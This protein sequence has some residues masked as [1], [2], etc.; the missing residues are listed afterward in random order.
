MKALSVTGR[1]LASPPPADW[2]EQLTQLLGAKPRRIGNWAELGL[3]GAMLCLAD[4]GEKT[5][6]LD[7]TLMLTSRRGTYAATGAALAQMGDGLPMPLTFLQTQPSQLL[8]LLSAQMDWMGHACFLATAQPQDLLRL[9]NAQMGQDG[10]LLGC[11]DEMD[12]GSS[13]WLR[14][15]PDAPEK[16]D[17]SAS[18][19]AWMP[20]ASV[21]HGV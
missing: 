8:A 12:G 21:A 7:A 9:A 1:C 13:N 15:R 14:L 10:V 18:F 17:F 20:P 19:L 2:R 6:P 3:Y 5:L 4:A 11:V 16:H